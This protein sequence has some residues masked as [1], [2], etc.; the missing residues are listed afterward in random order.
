MEIRVQGIGKGIF[1]PDEVVFTIQ[2]VTKG[3]SYDEVLQEGVY[4]VER[5]I[6]EVLKQNNLK[7]EEMKT[8]NFVIKEDKK[9]NEETGQYEKDGY[10][11]NQTASLVID[12]NKEIMASILVS[13]S[14]LEN[15][16][17]VTI[18]FG[19]KEKELCQKSLIEKAYQDALKQA[20]AIASASGKLLKD[21]Q[22]VDFVPFTTEYISPTML[23]SDSLYMKKANYDTIQAIENTLT[24][25]DIVLTETLYCLWITE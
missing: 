4:H 11:F 18:H 20:T 22:K 13:L 9:Y 3:S 7:K 10:S 21:C 14:K 25:E 2:F 15:P 8:R 12:Y 24:P 23:D 17:R 19:I 6:E 5:F 1:I 16:P